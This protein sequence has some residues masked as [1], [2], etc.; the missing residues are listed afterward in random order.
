MKIIRG[1]FALAAVVGLILA[2]ISLAHAAGS[3]PIVLPDPTIRACVNAQLLQGPGDAI[4]EDQAESLTNLECHGVSD[5]SGLPA[6]V[7]VTQV[8]FSGAGLTNLSPL[9][10]MPA[11]AEVFLDELPDQDFSTLMG[12]PN[13]VRLGLGALIGLQ[14]G[15]LDFVG[16]M[17]NLRELYLDNNEL[18]A[19]PDLSRLINLFHLG[20][21]DNQ[22]TD[23]S[24]L[25]ALPSLGV[26]DVTGN[27]VSDLSPIASAPGPLEVLYLS[28]NAILD[29][30]PLAGLVDL[31]EL[32]V[33]DQVVVLPAVLVGQGGNTPPHLI[34]GALVPLSPSSAA[35]SVDAATGSWILTALGNHSLT[36]SQTFATTWGDNVEFSGR[37]QQAAIHALPPSPTLPPTGQLEN[38][39][40]QFA[41]LGLLLVGAS[42]SLFARKFMFRSVN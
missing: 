7:N 27:R 14:P 3:D 10:L 4:T 29:L 11:L 34:D 2:P 37:I 23:L 20:V 42:M 5:L 36:W 40:L 41:A 19:L 39:G 31:I 18:T 30:R 25:A 38:Y 24:F 9:G 21:W 13:L 26:L 35:V 17:V 8:S 6:F 32:E 16:D 33:R 15:N 12:L 1:A 28:E 22:L